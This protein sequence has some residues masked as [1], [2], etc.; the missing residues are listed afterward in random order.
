MLRKLL[1]NI[2]RRIDLLL[3]EVLE[4]KETTAVALQWRG[5]HTPT[6]TELLLEMM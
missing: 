1:S 5:K 6:T 4:T 2:L 3:D